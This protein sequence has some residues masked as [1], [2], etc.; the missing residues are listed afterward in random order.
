VGATADLAAFAA[1]VTL[2]EVPE[3]ARRLSR[4]HLL[5]TLGVML[6]GSTTYGSRLTQELFAELGGAPQ[7]TLV[8]SGH[9]GTLLQAA[10]ANG[11]AGHAMDYD[12]TQLASQPG[13]VYGLLMHPSVPI[14]AAVLPIAESRRSIGADT[15]LAFMIGVEAACTVAEALMP[16]HYEHGFHTTGTCGA[17]G[18]A[19]AAGRLVGLDT[20]GI[21]RAVGL[22]ASTS[23][24]LRENFGTMTKPFH[25]GRAAENGVLAA[26][27][28]ARGHTA[29]GGILEAQR[30]FF[31]AYGGGEPSLVSDRLGN[32]WTILNPGIS[33]KPYPSGS[34]THPAIDAMLEIVIE[35]DV[36]PEQVAQIHAA[37]NHYMP[38]A[39]LHRAP[40]D[41]LQAKFSMQYALA[42]ALLDRRAGVAQF[43]DERVTSPDAQEWTARVEVEVD[44]TAERAGYDRMYSAVSVRLTDGT[45]LRREASFARGS[46]RRPMT[47]DELVAKFAECAA[48][49][50]LDDGATRSVVE[51]VEAIESL[52]DV[53]RLTVLH[54]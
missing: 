29:S 45:T 48:L 53:S 35:H 25:C 32:P 54:A 21:E 44:D 41:E 28:T 43:S 36:R 3:P 5:D 42:I 27:R 47:D 1:N 49:A 18:A 9:R 23:A 51:E 19:A 17:V 39:L 40:R 2:E 16:A 14:L 31:S 7:A 34:L 10:Y 6:A 22:A 33:I 38:D 11:E 4:R 15:L 30:G 8:G 12:D 46:P 13:R 52:D 24:G 20:A 50:G 26:V 37:V